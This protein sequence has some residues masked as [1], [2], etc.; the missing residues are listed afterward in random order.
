MAE[1]RPRS[2]LA[3]IVAALRRLYGPPDPPEVTDPWE[4][5]L[6]ESIAY[7]ATD[8]RR[9]T[10]W[11]ELEKRIG[12]RPEQILAAKASALLPIARAGILAADRVER[13]KDAAGIVVRDFGGDLGGALDESPVEA[14]KALRKFSGIGEPGAEKILLFSRREKVLALESNG[15]RALLRLGYGREEKSYAAS[16]RSLREATR[17][18]IRADFEWLIAA[19]QLLRRHG[20]ELCRRSRPLCDRCPL[21]RECAYFRSNALGA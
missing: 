8:E 6:F 13:L 4:M 18:E 15:L 19:H 17:P 10:A 21:T 9:R 16:Y 12:V 3:R 14:R 5:V 11:R 1:E 20:Q 2:R 7:L